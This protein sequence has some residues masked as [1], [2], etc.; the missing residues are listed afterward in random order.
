MAFKTLQCLAISLSAP[1]HKI[2]K[3]LFPFDSKVSISIRLSI[4]EEESSALAASS[5]STLLE[6]FAVCSQLSFLLNMLNKRMLVNS[7]DQRGY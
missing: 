5:G 1:P 2:Y 4:S 7:E 3:E 6:L